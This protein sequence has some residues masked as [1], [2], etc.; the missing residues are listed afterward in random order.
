[1]AVVASKRK[2]YLRSGTT[3][4]VDVSIKAFPRP[5][6]EWMKDY[7]P[8]SLESARYAVTPSGSLIIKDVKMSDKGS[9]SVAVTNVYMKSNGRFNSMVIH[10]LDADVSVDI[11][12]GSA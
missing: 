4:M 12:R 2:I 10:R 6:C 11:V 3:G 1:V 8:I 9:Y 7:E 5:E